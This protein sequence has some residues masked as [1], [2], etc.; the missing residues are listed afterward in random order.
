VAN[1]IAAKN[2]DNVVDFRWHR[3]TASPNWTVTPEEQRVADIEATGW[4]IAATVTPSSGGADDDD[5]EL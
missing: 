5:D 2:W 3:T 4:D 1:L